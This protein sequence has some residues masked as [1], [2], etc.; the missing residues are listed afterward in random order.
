MD[1]QASRLAGPDQAGSSTV[2][3]GMPHILVV[4]DDTIHRMI[5]LKVAAQSG[6]AV[7][8]A[9]TAEAASELISTRHYEC[10]VLDLKLRMH[11]GIE[12]LTQMNEQGCR[13]PVLLISSAGE[14]ARAA[15]MNLAQL[16]ALNFS[17]MPKPVDL[18]A[19]RKR[20]MALHPA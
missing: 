15:V 14:A 9:G 20:F 13:T 10:I 8:E 1:D 6:Y 17:D 18:A 4:D 3:A 16:Y 2:E 12:L 7:D 5:V 19:L 11:S